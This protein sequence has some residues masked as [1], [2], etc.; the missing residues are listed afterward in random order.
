[1]GAFL[2]Q[3]SGHGKFI[4]SAIFRNIQYLGPRKGL[5]ELRKKGV[6]KEENVRQC[7][8]ADLGCLSRDPDFCPSR[9]PNPTTAKKRKNFF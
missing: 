2:L 3:E 9:I 8:V 6:R 7:S 1:M 4:E 5:K